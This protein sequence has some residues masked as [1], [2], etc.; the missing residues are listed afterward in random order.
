MIKW[1]KTAPTAPGD[2]MMRAMETDFE[3]DPV[4]VRVQRGVLMA[5]DCDIGTLSVQMLHDG[6]TDCEWMRGER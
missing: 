1:Q 2:W 6:L 5:V 4:C 3:P